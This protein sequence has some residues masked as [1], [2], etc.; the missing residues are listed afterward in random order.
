MYISTLQSGPPTNAALPPHPRLQTSYPPSAHFTSPSAPSPPSLAPGCPSASSP[1]LTLSGFFNGMLEIFEPGALNYSTFSRLILSTL[2]A[3]RNSISTHLPI[4]EFSALRSDRTHSRPGILS[5]DDTHASSGVVTFVRQGLSFSELNSLPPLFLRLIPT[6][7]PSFTLSPHFPLHAL[8]LISPLSRPPWLSPPSWSGA[9][10]WRLCS[11]WQIAASAFLPTTLSV[12][13]RPLFPFREA[14]CVQVFPLKP[15]PFCMLFAGLSSTNK[16][17]TSPTIWLS[18]CP[19]L[20]L[21]F[22]LKLCGRSG[23]NCLLSPPALSDNGSPDTR[24]SQGATRLMSWQDGV[25][26]LHP[27]QSLVVSLL[28]CTLVFSRTGGV[29]SHQNLLAHRFPRFPPRNL[30]SLVF[31][32]TDTAYFLVLISLGLAESRILPAAPVDTRP[33]T[34]L[35][36]FCTVQLRT[37][38]AGHSCGDSLFL[39]DLWSRPWGVARLLGLHGLPPCPHPSEGVG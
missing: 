38:Y 3:S 1:I 25:R 24:F 4:S 10:D 19:L 7:L 28:L 36:S 34:P 6:P 22:H 17:A 5:A 21:S 15:A 29:L 14:Q 37:L 2:S 16:S 31:A 11:F 26:Y 33:R 30:S 12:A 18:F 32:A 39:Y 23:R 27:P 20:H 8:A 9:L 13:L 35:I